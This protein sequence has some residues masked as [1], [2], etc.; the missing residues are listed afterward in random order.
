ME[1]LAFPLQDGFVTGSTVPMVMSAGN[2]RAESK[3]ALPEQGDSCKAALSVQAHWLLYILQR[4]PWPLPC[5]PSSLEK[6]LLN[7]GAGVSHACQ[8]SPA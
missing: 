1:D 8:P 7:M 2:R 3:A 6:V 5:L 4:R